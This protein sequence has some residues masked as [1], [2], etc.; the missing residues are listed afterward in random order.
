MKLFSYTMSCCVIYNLYNNQLFLEIV[1]YG[2]YFT[3]TEWYMEF[4]NFT[5][6]E[7]G[8]MDESHMC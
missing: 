7:K 6:A 5:V 3:I 8:N 2:S 4:H 1:K